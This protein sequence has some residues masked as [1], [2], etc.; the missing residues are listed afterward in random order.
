[1]RF[2]RSMTKGLLVVGFAAVSSVAFAAVA[3]AADETDDAMRVYCLAPEHRD[4]MSEA[5]VALGLAHKEN[6]SY[7]LVN[8][9]PLDLASWW[10]D[11]P[12]DFGRTCSALMA[13]RPVREPDVTITQPPGP[14]A[15]TTLLPFLTGLVSAVL[16]FVAAAWRD[17]V[18]RGRGLADDLRLRFE[19]FR[20]AAAAYMSSWT[21]GRSGDQL[22]DRRGALLTQLAKVRATRR[23]WR[24]VRSIEDELTT[25]PLGEELTRNWAGQDYERTARLTE[26]LGELRDGLSRIAHEVEHPLR[27]W[28]AG[29]GRTG[30]RS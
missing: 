17:R 20:A 1:V 2:G 6:G 24:R 23:E 12:E 27:T 21:P 19:E 22:V 16:A 10:K 5:A 28:W 25:G 3:G 7:R 29:L 26:R 30:T 13:A 4:A 14:G 15:M 18:A 11:R 9:D 8:G